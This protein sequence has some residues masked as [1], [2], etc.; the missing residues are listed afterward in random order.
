[1][2]DTY[3]L[4]NLTHPRL[5][6]LGD[7]RQFRLLEPWVYAWRHDGHD[8]RLQLPAGFET[9]LAS[10][11]KLFHWWIGPSDLRAASLPHDLIYRCA[12]CLPRHLYQVDGREQGQPWAR[13]AAD[14][15]F[16]RLM[17]EAGVSRPRR[18]A[19]YLAVRVFGWLIWRR[20][21]KKLRSC[22]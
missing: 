6:L 19:A 20:A 7:W 16:A 2:P 21:A 15:L 14:R 5:E 18:R 10:V 22:G 17:R 13:H 12:G 8:H 3:T 9:D 11:P 4:I 1:M